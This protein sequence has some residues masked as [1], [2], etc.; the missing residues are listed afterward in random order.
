MNAGTTTPQPTSSNGRGQTAPL[1][2]ADANLMI[3][4][5][6]VSKRFG[7]HEVVRDLN[8]GI[9]QGEIFGF[10]GPSGSGKT[11]TIRLLTGVYAPSEGQVKLWACSPTTPRVRCRNASAI[12]RSFS[13]STQT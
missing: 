13:S 10:I 3:E 7:T 12:C 6:H 4:V 9:Q 1:Q 2:G 5:Q 8:F 11:T